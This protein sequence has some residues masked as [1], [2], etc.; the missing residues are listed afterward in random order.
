MEGGKPRPDVCGVSLISLQDHFFRFK[1]IL[2]CGYVSHY[3]QFTT[4]IYITILSL[5]ISIFVTLLYAKLTILPAAGEERK[6]QKREMKNRNIIM[7]FW[8]AIV[9]L[10]LLDSGVLY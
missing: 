5:N 2:S 3:D 10:W 6:N 7:N 4:S 9:G 8:G 1:P